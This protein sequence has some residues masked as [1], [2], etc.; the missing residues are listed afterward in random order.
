MMFGKKKIQELISRNSILA[1]RVKELEDILC[2]CEQ[3]EFVVAG[4]ETTY[5]YC[6]ASVEVLDKRK[7]ICRK[8]KKIVY[9]YDGC[10]S[11][12]KVSHD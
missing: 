8:C 4:I 5:S 7:L 2:P 9:D 10:G 3:H 12:Y 11:H 6:G 1:N